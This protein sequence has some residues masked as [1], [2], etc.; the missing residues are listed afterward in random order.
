MGPRQKSFFVGILLDNPCASFLPVDKMLVFGQTR[1]TCAKN[2][3][4][5][6]QQILFA[7]DKAF[8]FPSRDWVGSIC[9][10]G[11]SALGVKPKKS[12]GRR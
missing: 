4:S 12:E 2:L 5:H 3:P 7:L 1:I 9:L 6:L 11:P 10:H 8:V